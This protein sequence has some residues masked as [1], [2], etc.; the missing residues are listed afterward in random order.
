MST[1]QPSPHP[2]T[3]TF[4]ADPY[5]GAPKVLFVGYAES[6][7]THAWVD[8]LGGSEFNV[9][10]FGLPTL[11]PPDTWMVKSY[12]TG[13]GR[14]TGD[15]RLRK[16]AY[17]PQ[18]PIGWAYQLW[19][20]LGEKRGL[21]VPKAVKYE[22]A[23]ER[24][25]A[26]WRPDI[27]HTLGLE[28]ASFHM[29]TVRKELGG[30]L[31]G[32]WIV[33][34]RGGPDLHLH[35]HLPAYEEK[36]RDVFAACDEVI[37]DNE[38][39]Y[40]FALRLGLDPAKKSDVGIVPGT[41]GMDCDELG[42]AGTKPPS[43]RERIILW[44][45]AYETLSSKGIP[46]MEAIGLAWDDIA[47]CKILF[48]WVVQA[49]MRMWFREMLPEHIRA[50]CEIHGRLPR[51]KVIELMSE[52][53][54]ML[55]PSLTDGVPN[56]MYEAFACGAFPV[57]SPLPTITPVAKAPDN[58]LFARNLYPQEIADALRRAMNDNAL[59]DSAAERNR[60]LVRT[61]AGRDVIGPRVRKMYERIARGERPGPACDAYAA[62][63]AE[64]AGATLNG[65]MS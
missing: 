18:P 1:D 50:N 24:V 6:S 9:R 41:G 52:A 19:T 58:V 49:E 59:V 64:P 11:N 16:R 51:E 47:P 38:R 5:P 39:N 61:V 27:I 15:S 57:L 21:P 63:R 42:R 43:E 8:L 31:P 36:I 7:H 26:G 2:L 3:P 29:L 32:K 46:V 56:T 4:D 10:F 53:R 48:T 62:L 23:L 34:V 33:Q 28:P 54:V 30:K 35:R 12:A 45:K 40:E 14:M 55:A 37:C 13:P 65:V 20:K 60:G 22:T 17:P 25:L 44:P